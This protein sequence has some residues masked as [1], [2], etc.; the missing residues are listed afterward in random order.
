MK[1]IRVEFDILGERIAAIA[2]RYKSSHLTGVVTITVTTAEITRMETDRERTDKCNVY[3]ESSMYV[4]L[5]MIKESV[6]SILLC[7]IIS[8]LIQMYRIYEGINK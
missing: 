5:L 8:S 7:R 4:Q 1:F 6:S 3:N 2:S